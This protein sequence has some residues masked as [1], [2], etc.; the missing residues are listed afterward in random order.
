MKVLRDVGL[1]FGRAD[2]PESRDLGFANPQ[3]RLV[4]S[5]NSITVIDAQKCYSIL[6]A[7]DCGCVQVY[8][9]I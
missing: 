5:S 1:G 4:R 3:W 6:P 8:S 7:F 2:F 9:R